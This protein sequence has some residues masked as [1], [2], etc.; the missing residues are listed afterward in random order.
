MINCTVINNKTGEIMTEDFKIEELNDF[1]RKEFFKKKMELDNQ[2]KQGQQEYLGYFVFFIFEH[3]QDLSNILS[4]SDLVRFL[5]LGTY[6]KKDGILKFDNSNIITKENIKKILRLKDEAFRLF[7]NNIINN[8]LICE[9]DNKILINLFYFYRGKEKDYYNMTNRKF[10]D[11]FT[12][13]YIEATRNLYE[14]TNIR[15]IKKLAIIY[16]LLPFVNWQTNILCKNPKEINKY[17][18]EP[19]TILD[20][21]NY[22][23]YDKTHLARFRKEIHEFKYNNNDIF[24]RIGKSSDIN[25]DYIVV[26]PIFYYK[27]NNIEELNYLLTLFHIK[28]PQLIYTEDKEAPI[29]KN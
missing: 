22:L 23:K 25:Y 6:T 21:S 20:I 1:Q 18:I 14:N 16:K 27:G 24:M 13:L 8:K 19:L 5:Y 12:R 29:T 15:K 9:E 26:N 4:D 3:I 17:K 10:G 11:N 28:S 7:W 2:F